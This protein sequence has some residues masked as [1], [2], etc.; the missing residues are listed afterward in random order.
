MAGARPLLVELGFDATLIQLTREHRDLLALPDAI[1]DAGIAPGTDALRALVFGIPAFID[2]RD[3][4]TKI[5]GRLS[6]HAPQLFFILVGVETRAGTVTIAAFDS[7]KPRPRV[8]ALAVDR[9]GIVDSDCETVCALA[10]ARGSA[11]ILTHGRWLDILGRESISRRFFRELERVVGSLAGSLPPELKQPDAAELALLYVSRLVF[12]SF[13]ET[14]GWLDGDHAFLGNRFA[15]CM[16]TGGGYH[17]RV[18]NPLFFGT[19]N[20]SP[21]RRANRARQFGRIPF[22][23]GGLFS[24]TPLERRAS[25]AL[26]SDEAMGEVFGDLLTRYRFTAREDGTSWSE[27]AIDPEMLGR[28]FESLMSG[29]ERKGTGAYYTPHA[30]VRQVSRSALCYGLSSEHLGR[31]T[32]QAALDGSIIE[33]CN[34]AHLLDATA[35]L[36]ILDPAC[37][38]GAFLVHLLEELC[39]LRIRQGDLRTPHVVRREI[40]TRSIFGVDVNPMAVWLCELRLWLAIAIEDPEPDPIRV[41]PLPNL[42]RNIRIGD[43]LSG[44]GFLDGLRY[45][46]ASRVMVLRSRYARATG[47]RKRSLGKALDSVERDCAVTL[48]ERRISR[49]SAERREMLVMLRSPDLFGKRRYPGGESRDFLSRL[50]RD[51][52]SARR[53]LRRIRNGGGMAFSFASGFADASLEGGFGIIVGNPPWVRTHNLD[54]LQRG[55]LRDRYA[56][57]RN[58]AWAAGADAAH[59]GK[60]FASQVDASALFVE[61][62]AS[63]LQPGGTLSLIVPAKLWRSLA[64]GGVRNLLQTSLD[65]RELHDL[66]SAPQ[67]FEAAVYPSVITVSRPRNERASEVVAVVSHHRNGVKKWTSSSRSIAFDATPGSPWLIIPPDVR[68]AFDRLRARGIPISRTP[69]GR[70]LLGVKTGCNNAFLVGNSNGFEP[71]VLR[72]AVRG[73]DVTKWTVGTTSKRIIWTHDDSGPLRVLPPRVAHHLAGWRHELES[74]TDSRGEERWWRLFRTEGADSRHARV[75]WS[76]IGKAPTAAILPAGDNSVPLNTCY[77]IKC[78][79]HSDAEALATILNCRLPGAWLGALAEPARGG[80]SRFMGWTIALLPLPHDWRRARSILA[81]IARAAV[82][83]NPP[84][85]NELLESVL[86]AYM[87]SIDEVFALLQWSS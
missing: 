76:D 79:D 26:F 63:L 43:S 18:L 21:P 71:C 13:I 46:Q 56:V 7:A 50:R 8:A 49:L 62:C 72:R 5:A 54:P 44:D 40:L 35:K 73:D 4:I 61:R 52:A 86:D 60:G 82:A 39:S 75:V 19:L 27:A 15:D 69:L 66:T 30:L 24:R 3:T 17:R 14:K 28:A 57:Y 53:E 36:R 51:L 70:P 83:G 10:A 12:L 25:Q 55:A 2:P 41:T 45:R 77:V 84:D 23:N 81:P 87:L 85:D 22:L 67:S 37:G 42:D 38:S 6:T 64:G 74:R 16:M 78:P 47:P 59:A 9:D 32:I 1:E 20:T 68:A 80:Y 33:C 48:I 34:R 58:A 11:D 65:I 29:S 31:E